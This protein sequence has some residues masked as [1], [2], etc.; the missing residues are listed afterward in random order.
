MV[1]KRKFDKVRNLSEKKFKC[2]FPLGKFTEIYV[3]MQDTL[4]LSIFI[5]FLKIFLHNIVNDDTLLLVDNRV[6]YLC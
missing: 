6:D 2:T 1:R 5:D 3:L 4:Y